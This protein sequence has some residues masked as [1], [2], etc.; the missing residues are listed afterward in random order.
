LY[1]K[2]N[3]QLLRTPVQVIIVTKSMN[4]FR[5]GVGNPPEAE[6]RFAPKADREKIA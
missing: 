6:E 2:V 4:G 1:S 5:N 3:P